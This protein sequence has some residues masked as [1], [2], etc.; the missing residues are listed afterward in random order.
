MRVRVQPA[1]LELSTPLCLLHPPVSPSLPSLRFPA[2]SLSSF[3]LVFL[4][5]RLSI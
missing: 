1:H 5:P 2:L 4:S 3:S